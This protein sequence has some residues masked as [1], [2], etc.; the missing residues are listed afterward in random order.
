MLSPGRKKCL[1]VRLAF[2]SRWLGPECP[3]PEDRALRL[4]PG[5]ELPGWACDA[6]PKRKKR[7]RVLDVNSG[8]VSPLGTVAEGRDVELVAIDSLAHNFNT[9]MQEAGLTPPVPPLPCAP[10]DVLVTFGERAFDLV[11]SSNGLD[12]T[13][14]PIVIYRQL[15]GCLKP[16]G[17]IITFHETTTD[18]GRIHREGYRFFHVL[19]KRRPAIQ[20]KGYRRDL[21]DALPEARLKASSEHGFLRLEIWKPRHARPRLRF[22]RGPRARKRLPRMISMHLPK[23][24]GSS[25]RGFLQHLYG[26]SLRCLYDAEETSPRLLGKVRLARGTR[27]LHGHFQADAYD[28]RLR[29][30]VKITWLRD[31]VERIVSSYYQ[32]LRNPETAADFDFNKRII[33]GGW[34][35]MDFAREESMIR[36]TRW[37]F[38]AVPLEKFLFI[39]IAEEFGVSLALLCRLLGVEPPESVGNI[40]TNPQKRPESRY[41]LTRAQREELNGLYAE[42][43]ELYRYARYRLQAQLDRVFG[44]AAPQLE[45]R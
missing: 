39:G 5:R 15:L 7:V 38:N 8:P 22:P 21:Q 33:M 25:F 2:W 10:T 20:Q 27:C 4:T 24:A 35:L 28:D 41:A 43:I 11:Y 1:E 31:P 12:L 13:E 9:L 23:A 45:T 36:Q 17:R 14:D 44:K 40:N 37:Y 32:Y 30:A 26:N 16:G 29:G 34:S 6:L 3:Y 19:R 42:E 18:L